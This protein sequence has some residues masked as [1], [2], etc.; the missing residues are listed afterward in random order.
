MVSYPVTRCIA[1][2]GRCWW[3]GLLKWVEYFSNVVLVRI[4]ESCLI[5]E[6]R[7]L[8]TLVLSSRDTFRQSSLR[9]RSFVFRTTRLVKDAP[10]TFT[11]TFSLS[12]F[13]TN[14][15]CLSILSPIFPLVKNRFPFKTRSFASIFASCLYS[16]TVAER[17]IPTKLAK[18]SSFP[19]AKHSLESLTQRSTS[20]VLV[21]T[22]KKSV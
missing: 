22:V 9:L 19:D 21:Q 8:R 7:R 3:L 2:S 20:C 1:F 15:V 12:C 13:S 6:E 10:R 5:L 4:V 11:F 14:P 18:C 16:N 17:Q